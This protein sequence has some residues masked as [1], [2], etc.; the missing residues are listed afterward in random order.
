[1]SRVIVRTDHQVIRLIAAGKYAWTD[2]QSRIIAFRHDRQ[3]QSEAGDLQRSYICISIDHLRRHGRVDLRLQTFR[4]D[5][6]LRS[7][8]VIRNHFLQLFYNCCARMLCALAVPY[9]IYD[10]G[11]GSGEEKQSHD[12]QYIPD[13]TAI[14]LLL[15]HFSNLM[16][17]II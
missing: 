6:L 9:I 10:Q 7:F 12:D 13:N 2:L 8:N 16:A 15:F 11:K 17:V 14:L 4:Y 5:H 3:I 1:M